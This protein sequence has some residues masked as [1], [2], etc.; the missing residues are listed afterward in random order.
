MDRQEL[1]ILAHKVC[2]NI[3]KEAIKNNLTDAEYDFYIS[4]ILYNIAVGLAKSSE[5]K[6]LDK[7][8]E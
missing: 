6:L 5:S 7:G 3:Y 8:E 2:E 4:N 1:Y